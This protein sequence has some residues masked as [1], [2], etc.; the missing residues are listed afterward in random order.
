MPKPLTVVQSPNP[1]T[2]IGQ[3]TA[4]ARSRTLFVVCFGFFLVLLDTTALNIATPALG[5]EFGN[6]ISDLQWV[7]NSYTLVF[8]SL[9]L[10]AGAVGDRTG[11]KRSYQIGLALFTG[12]SLFSAVA[13]CLSLLIAARALQGLGA[14]IMLPASLAVLSHTFPEPADRS[15]AVTTWANTASL[16]FAAGPVLGGVL[17]TYLGWRSIFWLNVPVGIIALLL[18]HVHIRETKLS[19][20]RPIDWSGQL[21]IGLALFALTYALIEVGRRGWNDPIVLGALGCVILLLCLFVGLERRSDHPVLPGFLFSQRIF[22]ACIGVGFVLN[23]SMYGILF[24]ESVYLQSVRG[25]DAFAT[26]LTITPFT[27][28]PTIASRLLGQRNGIPYLRPRISLGLALAVV[29]TSV[30]LLGALNTAFWPIPVG[31]GLLGISMG[32]IMPAMTAGVLVSAAPENS[33]LASGLLNSM[34]QVG[35]TVGVAL[36]GTA[37]QSLAPGAGLACALG[38][39]GLVLLFAAE[40]SRRALS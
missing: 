21:S 36:L 26:G 23:F 11:V 5:K 18:N 14:A 12:T 40:V 19:R 35:G 7:I 20:P 1:E 15:Q 30:L 17:T 4:R 28:F 31:L 6:G 25:M 16:G 9:L 10:T 29:G 37:M 3:L 39:T 2:L 8:A 38:I 34:R 32:T 33:G 24:I 22:S 27:I 13:P